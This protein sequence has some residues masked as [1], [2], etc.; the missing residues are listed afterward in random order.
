[1][2]FETGELKWQQAGLGCGSLMIADGH[3]LL[4]SDD[5]ELVL[6]K[7]TPSEFTEVARSS[8]L[9]GHCWTAPVLLGGRIY[10]RTAR[11][12]A[13]CVQLPMVD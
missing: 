8:F 6:A 12:Q 11:G 9:T 13:V 2:D 3:L 1:M 5:G 10:G 4:L 7:A